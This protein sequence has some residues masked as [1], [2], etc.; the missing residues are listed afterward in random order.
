MTGFMLVPR[1]A[2]GILA[3]VALAREK[4][5][6]E[7]RNLIGLS[8]GSDFKTRCFGDI[9]PLSN[10]NYYNFNSLISY[11]KKEKCETTLE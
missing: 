4:T 10:V 1:A 9:S 2:C 3:G 11:I 7:I 5:D 8:L 6:L